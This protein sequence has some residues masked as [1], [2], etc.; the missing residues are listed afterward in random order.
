MRTATDPRKAM[1]AVHLQRSYQLLSL[2]HRPLSRNILEVLSR[3][4]AYQLDNTHLVLLVNRLGHF[5]R[6]LMQPEISV[7]LSLLKSKK[8]ILVERRGKHIFY[9]INTERVEQI[10]RAISRFIPSDH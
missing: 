5:D 10:Q 7:M 9:A 8:I 3:Y 2:L 1:F 6:M 4:P